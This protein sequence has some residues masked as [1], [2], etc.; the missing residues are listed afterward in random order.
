MH[1]GRFEPVQF[2]LQ[3][4]S[5]TQLFHFVFQLNLVGVRTPHNILEHF[6]VFG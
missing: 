1:D 6:I 5:L 2:P 3:R 4:T